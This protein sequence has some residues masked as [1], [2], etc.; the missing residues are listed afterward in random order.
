MSGATLEA[1]AMRKRCPF[2]VS[3]RCIGRRCAAWEPSETG[4]LFYTSQ[5]MQCQ[6]CENDFELA[7]AR[8]IS[9]W[10]EERHA[11]IKEVVCPA[12]RKGTPM[13]NVAAPVTRARALDL[14]GGG[15]C[16]R[17]IGGGK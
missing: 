9:F 5:L 16:L 17:L 1:I 11:H 14:L 7:V 3:E 10:S 6:H 15:R 2:G 8:I 12:C 13:A 4:A